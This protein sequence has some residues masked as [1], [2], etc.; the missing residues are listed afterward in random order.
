MEN[1]QTKLAAYTPYFEAIRKK[2]ISLAIVFGV[3]FILGF[4]ETGSVIKLVL[5]VFKLHNVTVVTTSPFQ[6]LNLSTTIAMISGSTAFF[7][8]LIYHSYR[9][10]RDGLRKKE[11]KLFFFLV[12]SGIFLFILGVL[13]GFG[14]LYVYLES[15][16]HINLDLGV[17]NVWDITTF[18][19]QMILTSIFLGFVFQFPILLTFFI[20]IGM[21][22]ADYLRRKRKIAF[23]VI[24]LFVGFL[25]PPDIFSTFIEAFPLIVLYEL[26]IRVNTPFEKKRDAIRKIQEAEQQA[27][28]N[29]P[30]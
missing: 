2:L 30:L 6:L 25:P 26:A 1:L 19:S 21:L 16:A 18:L 3:F 7:L 4:I 10:M 14:V 8:V 9:F 17:Q 23:I 20:R 15:V 13:Y 11:R 29:T 24:F 12:T 5:G 22:R 27:E 28:L